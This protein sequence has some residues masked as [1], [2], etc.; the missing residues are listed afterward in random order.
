[1]QTYIYQANAHWVLHERGAVKCEDIGQTL[2]FSIPVEFGGEPAFWTPEHLLLASVASCYVA[3]FRA[4]AEK[5]SL[6]F[7]AVD[8]TVHGAI[9]KEEGRLRFTRVTLS[10]AISIEKESDR[11]RTVRLAEKAEQGCLIARS[12]SAAFTLQPQILVESP[13]AA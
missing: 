2:D 7:H 3:T 8:V 11:E 5:S 13:V 6:E 10:P 1:M 9:E 12:L 4:M